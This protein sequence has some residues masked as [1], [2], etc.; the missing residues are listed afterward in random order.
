M[1]VLFLK[2]HHKQKL[3]N[4]RR[5]PGS[6]RGPAALCSPTKG[7]PSVRVGHTE[8][9]TQA[10]GKRVP[11]L[12][13]EPPPPASRTPHPGFQP[14]TPIREL[15]DTLWNVASVGPTL[16]VHPR[17]RHARFRELEQPVSQVGALPTHSP[18]WG[19][20]CGAPGS[21]QAP[22]KTTTAQPACLSPEAEPPP[23]PSL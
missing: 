15:A 10:A 7:S 21:N 6:Q 13:D 16:I 17:D 23:A 8:V 9:Q 1:S 2:R 5:P 18:R 11:A 4:F 22:P 14:P 3:D 12:L 20:I 19:Q